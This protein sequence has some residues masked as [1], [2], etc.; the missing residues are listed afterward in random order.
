A[1]GRIMVDGRYARLYEHWIQEPLTTATLAALERARGAGT[2]VKEP[3][4][5]RAGGTAAGGASETAVS[6]SAFTIRW[7]LLRQA[8]PRLLREGART[9]L[10]LTLLTLMLGVPAGLLV[11][12]RRIAG[13][14]SGAGAATVCV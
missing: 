7:D 6:G 1:L 8:L 11:A 14:A 13:E 10:A 9:T 3:S 12:V 2:P 5:Y 4:E